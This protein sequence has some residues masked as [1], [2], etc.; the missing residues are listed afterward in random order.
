MAMSASVNAQNVL[1]GLPVSANMDIYR[2]GGYDDGSD[3]VAPAAYAFPSGRGHVLSFASVAGLW[4][5]SY[6]IADFGPDGSTNGLCY[7]HS[8]ETP[9]GT[10]SGYHL[11]DFAG[12]MA[13][14]FL[15]DAL[16][17]RAPIP[18]RFYVSDSSEGGI[19]TDFK[20]LSPSIGQ[21]FFV[22]DG[23]T[24]SGLRETQRFLVP[25]TATHL[26]LGFVDACTQPP[27]ATAPGCYS[28][29]EGTLEAVFRIEPRQF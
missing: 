16:P 10:F 2:A 5:C 14:V 29:N 13:A 17:R 27:P 22:G 9:I 15:E 8:I 4:T 21:I 23:L 19:P 25:P 11:T 26:Y 20:L 1:T 6:A 7:G 12:A 18:L 28:D 3:G 24:G